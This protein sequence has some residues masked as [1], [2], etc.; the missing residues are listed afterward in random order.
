MST[1]VLP[2]LGDGQYSG[3][4]ITVYGD[5][6]A[7]PVYDNN[8]NSGQ[9][10]LTSL[11]KGYYYIR[12]SI[13]FNNNFTAYTLNNSFTE[14]TPNILVS[15]GT[16]TAA[17]C[18]STNTIV[19]KFNRVNPPY[20][21]QLYRFGQAYG[22]PKTV[23]KKTYT[24][25]NLPDGAYYATALVDGASVNGL[26]KSIGMMPKPT[27]TNTTAITKSQAKLNWTSVSCADYY[28]VQYRVHGTI[29]WTTKKTSGN[30]NN[31]VIKG[32]TASKNYEWHV[33]AVDSSNNISATSAYTDHKIF[34]TFNSN[35]R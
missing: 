13:Q 7:A 21:L 23:N 4:R 19:Y 33:A 22:T 20:I 1:N 32:L 11:A 35:C 30:V 3:L 31:I 5:T 6:S 9:V 28:S 34:N 15:D 10:N 27:G 29:A 25:N 24:F 17:D 12:I 26:S 8:I 2:H 16:D 14:T 18:L